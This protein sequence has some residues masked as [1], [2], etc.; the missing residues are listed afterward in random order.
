MHDF[1]VYN[2]LVGFDYL[3]VTKMNQRW[4]EFFTN[5]E[6]YIKELEQNIKISEKKLKNATQYGS[7]EDINQ[8][9]DQVLEKSKKD[10]DYVDNLRKKVRYLF[11]I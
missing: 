2:L 8:R 3:K 6:A 5:R 1:C 10:L 4:Q 11:D 7:T 9:I